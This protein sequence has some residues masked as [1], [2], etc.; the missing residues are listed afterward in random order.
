MRVH[1]MTLMVICCESFRVLKIAKCLNM[2]YNKCLAIIS[3]FA[4]G[5]YA[6]MMSDNALRC[7]ND[8]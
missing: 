8:N 3:V 2:V 6:E 4:A 7:R 1:D 5:E